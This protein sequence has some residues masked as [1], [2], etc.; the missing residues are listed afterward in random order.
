MLDGT[1]FSTTLSVLDP[2]PAS[3]YV[4][5]VTGISTFEGVL[6]GQ[7]ATG[8]TSAR[9]STI[10]LSGGGTL[11]NDGT[12]ALGA[13]SL[14]ASAELDDEGV[15]TLSEARG[16]TPY[17][18]VSMQNL[19]NLVNDGSITDLQGP[20]LVGGTLSGTGTITLSSTVVSSAET[21]GA[22]LDVL[23]P[24]SA[25]QVVDL[26][27]VLDSVHLGNFQHPYT[28]GLFAGTIR[29][30][31]SQGSIFINSA[32]P[33]DGASF[34]NDDLT[35]TSSGTPVLHLHV[36]G[37][38]AANAFYVS[39]N[40]PGSNLY[41]ASVAACYAIGTRILT[42]RGEVPVE[43][44]AV[45]DRALTVLGQE[46]SPIRWIGH[47][48][49]DLRRH[50]APELVRP[51]RVRADAFGP[52]RPA[53]D[54]CVS[55]GHALHVDGV[56]I[57]AERL[58]NGISV[59]QEAWDRVTYWH[60]ELERHDV[61]LAEGLPTESYLDTGNR[62]AFAN[63]GAFLELHPDFKPRHAAETGLDLRAAGAEVTIH[64]VWVALV[65]R[66]RQTSRRL[67]LWRARRWGWWG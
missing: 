22:G 12:I 26:V 3:E 23:G 14:L 40:P 47:R 46:L 48:A 56:L 42:A 41:R 19:Q 21:D 2:Y 1:T 57:Q 27:G 49:L 16:A 50:P 20:I 15:I 55:P 62:A 64:R 34:S 38:Y 67:R 51:V 4:L 43:E 66:T 65:D 6:L 39:A 18:Q 35:L 8:A 33:L 10:V 53:R 61:L 30:F 60:V 13:T 17:R 54:L 31:N 37:S 11:V 45:G 7:P 25:G 52:A 9:T 29:D 36:V 63:G 5:S 44:L 32:V 24:V 59:V 28:D 58:V